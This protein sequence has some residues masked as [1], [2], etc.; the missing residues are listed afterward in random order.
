MA[1]RLEGT[2]REIEEH[3]DYIMDQRS[4]AIKLRLRMEESD[5]RVDAVKS[6]CF[7]LQQK[8]TILKGSLEA[9]KEAYSRLAMEA[10]R[11][12]Q[13]ANAPKDPIIINADSLTASLARDGIAHHPAEKMSQGMV[14]YLLKEVMEYSKQ[15]KS[16]AVASRTRLAK[17]IRDLTGVSLLAVK[18]IITGIYPNVKF[19]STVEP[20]TTFQ[21]TMPIGTNPQNMPTAG[22]QRERFGA[23]GAS[24]PLRPPEKAIPALP[25]HDPSSDLPTFKR[26]GTGIHLEFER[27]PK[28]I[29]A[30]P[31]P[32][33]DTEPNPDHEI[34]EVM[35][36]ARGKTEPPSG[37]SQGSP[38]S[39]PIV[40]EVET[41]TSMR[42][43]I[44][45]LLAE[46][47]L[48]EEPVRQATIL[49]P[50]SDLPPLPPI[51]ALPPPPVVA[52]V[53]RVENADGTH[54]WR[55]IVNY[56][57][58]IPDR[59]QKSQAT[60][61]DQY[62]WVHPIPRAPQTETAKWHAEGKGE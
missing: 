23:W 54:T 28:L 25:P 15:D 47:I 8:L 1:L 51:Q 12:R 55:S 37:D 46:D 16:G 11:L 18:D 50:S 13:L 35:A 45:D 34:Q 42:A 49:P 19:A 4:E 58:P 60:C 22:V 21:T 36:F 48:P 2:P 20:G 3:I 62:P 9:E 40:L 6:E 38:P 59:F 7:Q 33:E 30:A 44:A 29:G 41:P 14:V 43:A 39:A 56:P 27:D 57:M 5:D 61:G 32:I 53:E 24:S 17:A 31:S 26:Q 52:A 10:H